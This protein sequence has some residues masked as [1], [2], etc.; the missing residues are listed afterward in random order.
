MLCLHELYITFFVNKKN[1]FSRKTE[2]LM[3][4]QHFLCYLPSD[5]LT[6]EN[7][8]YDSFLYMSSKVL[9]YGICGIKLMI[10]YLRVPFSSAFMSFVMILV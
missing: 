3:K 8:L 2:L 7:Y 1:L 10:A 5:C 4:C 6:V 9:D